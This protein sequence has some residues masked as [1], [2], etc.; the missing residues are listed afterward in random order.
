MKLLTA[1]QIRCL[2]NNGHWNRIRRCQERPIDDF[3]PV[4]KL[5]CLWRPATWLLTEITHPD[6]DVAYGLCDL[7]VGLPEVS[8]VRLSSLKTL[9]SSQGAGIEQDR[10][11]RPI[12]T[13]AGYAEKSRRH[14]RTIA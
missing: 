9:R 8:R 6:R 14:G 3:V 5:F 7:G 10:Y 13:L 11:F 1:N 4:V 2:V 12:M